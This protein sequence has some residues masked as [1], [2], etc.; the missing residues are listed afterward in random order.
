M[1]TPSPIPES[2]PVPSSGS[3]AKSSELSA[4]LSLDIGFLPE[5]APISSLFA[6]RSQN[7]EE[8]IA[9]LKAQKEENER[10]HYALKQYQL[11]KS[12]TGFSN[13]PRSK[14]FVYEREGRTG[15]V[16]E[17]VRSHISSKYGKKV[18]PVTDNLKVL[19]MAL[20]MAKIPF[21]IV[22]SLEGETGK[23]DVL[24]SKVKIVEGLDGR[25]FIVLDDYYN[26]HTFNLLTIDNDVDINDANFKNKLAVF[27]FNNGRATEPFLIKKN[28]KIYLCSPLNTS[29]SYAEID[30]SLT[31]ALHWPEKSSIQFERINRIEGARLDDKLHQRIKST[32]LLQDLI[33]YRLDQ[34]LFT[35]GIYAGKD[36]RF[37]VLSDSRPSTGAS[38]VSV[39]DER[40]RSTLSEVKDYVYS[41]LDKMEKKLTAQGDESAAFQY[42]IINSLL[43]FDS[44]YEVIAS[45]LEPNRENLNELPIKANAGFIRYGGKL[46]YV[47]KLEKKCQ[48]LE[49][50]GEL[51][52]QFDAYLH[53]STIPKLLSQKELH[54]VV[55]MT[56]I[57]DL[58]LEDDARRS[59]LENELLRTTWMRLAYALNTS[60]SRIK[61]KDVADPFRDDF[62]VAIESAYEEVNL[63]LSL[64]KTYDEASIKHHLSDYL[65]D[66]FCIAERVKEGAVRPA[67]PTAQ[68]PLEDVFL[69]TSG[70]GA[71]T[72]MI[73]TS[74]KQ[75][76]EHEKI[77]LN[78]RVYFELDIFIR[79]LFPVIR[80]EG[81]NIKNYES[82]VLTLENGT[83]KVS[84]VGCDLMRRETPPTVETLQALPTHSNEAYVRTGD[85]LF[86]INKTDKKCEEIRC[87][88]MTKIDSL[89]DPKGVAKTL[90][91]DEMEIITAITK[92]AT[93]FKE[94]VNVIIDGFG[95][96]VSADSQTAPTHYAGTDIIASIQKQMEIRKEL[97]GKAER[98]G[99][100]L[101][102]SGLM[103][104]EKP[105]VLTMDK[106][107]L[108]LAIKEG[109]LVCYV[110]QESELK[111][112]S[113]DSLKKGIDT[114]I[115]SQLAEAALSGD[116]I[117]TQEQKDAVFEITTKEGF[118]PREYKEEPLT[119]VLDTTMTALKHIHM[120][121]LLHQF[122]EE[123]NSGKLAILTAHS[124]N[125]HAGMGLDRLSCGV[126]SAIYNKD[127][128]PGLKKTFVSSHVSF[129]PTDPT[130]AMT[131]HQLE[132]AY[133]CMHL[134][135]DR[136]HQNSYYIHKN[137]VPNISH[138]G[139]IYSPFTRETSH[140][141]QDIWG[142][143][144]IDFTPKPG[145]SL[146]YG[147]TV[148]RDMLSIVLPALGI[149]L[150]DGYGFSNSVCCNIGNFLRISIGSESRENIHF[151]Y[152]II[153]D[154]LDICEKLYITG[155]TNLYSTVCSI[156]LTA[157]SGDEASKNKKIKEIPE[158]L[159]KFTEERINPMM[160]K[161]ETKDAILKAVPPEFT[162]PSQFC[163]TTV[164]CIY[165]SLP[166]PP[167]FSVASAF[168]PMPTIIKIMNMCG[169][170][171]E[172]DSERDRNKSY[173]VED[174]RGATVIVGNEEIQELKS[175]LQPIVKLLTITQKMWTK[176]LPSPPIS[177]E[178]KKAAASKIRVK[179]DLFL[180][181]ILSPEFDK[182]KLPEALARFED[183]MLTPPK[184]S[185][186]EAESATADSAKT[187]STLRASSMFKAE[188]QGTKSAATSTSSDQENRPG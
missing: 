137:L 17:E 167:A 144:Y 159:K 5:D 25:N 175:K 71:L 92:Q 53:P 43:V 178:L 91:R 151:K 116:A 110:R 49:V 96:N 176:E 18:L 115:R 100:T 177:E 158:L 150:R 154:F 28:D 184:I 112:I 37:S 88:D 34:L 89:M 80:P 132:K 104:D 65:K 130:P 186:D 31:E 6:L 147:P 141:I 113:L 93:D 162:N 46:Y 133:P 103:P 33:S 122:Q 23:K 108:Y 1:S 19:T 77:Y 121:L 148:K 86:Y 45:L 60:V 143:L 106:R 41:L 70:M 26:F 9:K 181:E 55:T 97:K 2:V 127:H 182:N 90:S 12:L 59:P 72:Q 120:P 78:R 135:F 138:I 47:N 27:A 94:K 52:K 50:K 174:R 128:F 109:Q 164:S 124:F 38:T 58:R 180:K 84:P 102:F 119:V 11:S 48:E 22:R 79:N 129:Q 160:A 74:I 118:K 69:S 36:A 146:T 126:A 51:L 62:H 57:R 172:R 185:K 61:G 153:C 15:S 14:R 64:T 66:I 3:T 63:I 7:M 85:K 123:I 188:P 142:F 98:E 111:T 152:K 179:I 87:D 32:G 40:D 24:A 139:R 44:S 67:F 39:V 107:K 81:L 114:S 8:T 170:P 83:L 157:S 30:S 20:E 82:V 173:V 76:K 10:N 16:I 155:Q 73:M 156:F 42:K 101:D 166:V 131:C 149:P 134:H 4:D 105:N 99:Y 169:L 95:Q 163:K 145:G 168:M 29:F 35:G 165:D 187:V 171:K 117:L 56:G 21:E 75:M 54:T 140:N 136:A 68:V 125:K 183:E 13:S 161:R